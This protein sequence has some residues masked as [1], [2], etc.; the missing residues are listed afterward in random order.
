MQQPT[1]YRAF[2]PAPLPPSPPLDIDANMVKLLAEAERSIGRLDGATRF[3]PD[4]D[5]FVAQ[6]VRKEAVLSSQIEGTQSSLDDI[7]VYEA[8][9]GS[10]RLPQDIKEV[11]NYVLAMKHGL[12]RL[13]SLPLSLRLLRE[14]HEVLL[15]AGRGAEKLPGEFRRSQNWIGPSNVPLS[16]ASFVPPPPDDMWRSLDD[17]ER[18]L[19]DEELPVLIHCGLAHAQFETI[20]PFLDGN[21]RVGRL[22]ITLLLCHRQVLE[23]P[24]LYLSYYFKLYRQEYYDRL[25]AIRTRG[26]WEGWLRF[27]LR[28]IALTADDAARTAR[29]I[30]QL[31]DS[32]REL[33]QTRGL[34]INGWKLL[35]H[36]YQAP[37]V[38]TKSTA[39]SL[40]VVPNTANKILR[41]FESIGLL[42][43]ITGRQRS[44]LYRYTPYLSLFD[45]PMA[46]RGADSQPEAT[47]SADQ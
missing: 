12:Q 33:V 10:S 27:F 11:V 1:G 28:G 22:L 44:R 38:N 8:D 17:L 29:Q 25:T 30:L 41:Q 36:L 34:G 42:D 46:N 26:D 4:P 13:D 19:H 18:F 32:H 16:M 7:L 14:I 24:L 15:Q 2:I 5:L 23:Y 35:D 21:G 31:R 9:P 6:Y 43:E 3:I 39:Q 45:E 47:E 20:H 37:I 40:D